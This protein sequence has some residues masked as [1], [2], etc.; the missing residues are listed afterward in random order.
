MPSATRRPRRS[1]SREEVVD[2]S[3]ELESDV[4]ILEPLPPEVTFDPMN[5]SMAFMDALRMITEDEWLRYWLYLYRLDPKVKNA[6]D[7]KKYI[8]RF[9]VGVDEDDVQEQHGGGKYMFTLVERTERGVSPKKRDYKFSIAGDPKFLPGQTVAGATAA[10]AAA[11][12]PAEHR[13]DS[14]SAALVRALPALIETLKSN[15]AGGSNVGLTQ[16]LDVMGAASKASVTMMMEAAKLSITSPTGNQLADRLLETFLKQGQPQAPQRS[17]IE[18]KLITLALS[19]LE[20]PQPQGDGGFG[21][22]GALKDLLGVDNIV[23][24]LRPGGGAGD[25]WKSKLVEM[26]ASFIGNIPAILQFIAANQERA[27]RREMQ[28]LALQQQNATVIPGGA[29][30][31]PAAAVPTYTAPPRAPGPGAMPPGPEMM[32]PAL[33]PIS[34]ALA[35]IV[36]CFDSGIGG[37]GCAA[38]VAHKYPEFV[39]AFSALLTDRDQVMLFA[40]ST[41][42]LSEVAS[43]EDFPAFLDQFIQEMLTP[44]PTDGPEVPSA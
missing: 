4:D 1:R 41:E 37:D 9:Q 8:A 36:A 43:E 42:P 20:N 33:D 23:D 14:E 3:P 17:A 11:A 2:V 44:E 18:D 19:R 35:D 5:E 38:L 25:V 32:P 27:M 31:P 24:L 29:I 16:A 12:P 21:Q 34:M 39:Q 40:K 6:A 15:G 7:D 22:L 28:M 10:V 30:A 26:G 13:E